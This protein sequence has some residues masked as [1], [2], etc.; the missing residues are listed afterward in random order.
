MTLI[1]K[2]LLLIIITDFSLWETHFF[3]MNPCFDLQIKVTIFYYAPSF[4][5]SSHPACQN[6]ASYSNGLRSRHFGP[7]AEGEGLTS[8]L[9]HDTSGRGDDGHGREQ[10]RNMAGFVEQ[11]SI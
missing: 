1:M 11:G 10:Q 3:Q 2:S 4:L 7:A 9:Q 8:L 6:V 5:S